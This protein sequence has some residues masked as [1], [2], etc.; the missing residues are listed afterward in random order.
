MSTKP[1]TKDAPVR[2]GTR[3]RAVKPNY[4]AIWL[5]GESIPLF[6]QAVN[7]ATNE[8]MGTKW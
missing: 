8:R 7:I 5:D 4:P 3:T 2:A 1:N 6:P